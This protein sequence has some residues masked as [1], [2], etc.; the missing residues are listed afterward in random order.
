MLQLASVMARRRFDRTVGEYAPLRIEFLPRVPSIDEALYWRAT[1]PNQ[2]LEVKLEART[3]ALAEINVVLVAEGAVR[4]IPS[5]LNVH[6]VQDRTEGH[7]A[8][9]IE[10]WKRKMGGRELVDPSLRRIDEETKFEL[11]IADDGVAVMIDGRPP[12]RVVVDDRAWFYFDS[13]DALSAVVCEL[14]APDIRLLR[15]AYPGFGSVSRP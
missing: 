11:A 3:G 10:P 1:G 4:A 7:P 5:V 9:R 8:F 12:T 15:D 14:T 2:L 6:P 13:G